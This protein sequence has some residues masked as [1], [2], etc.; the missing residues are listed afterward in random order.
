MAMREPPPRVVNTRT[1]LP[2]FPLAS[3]QVRNSNVER[4]APTRLAC[5][6]PE[7]ANE[8]AGTEIV[9]DL[10]EPSAPHIELTLIDF[11]QRGTHV[12]NPVPEAEQNLQIG[13]LGI[14]ADIVERG[15]ARQQTIEA[16]RPHHFP[17]RQ[18]M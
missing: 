13:A 1:P 3:S 7:C 10:G 17:G 4:I 9:I 18:R 8:A 5:F 12:R 6:G 15:L 16:L 11:D 2:F 14:D